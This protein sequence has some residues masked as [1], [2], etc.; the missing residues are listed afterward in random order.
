[1][2]HR[3]SFLTGLAALVAAPAIVRAESLMKVKAEP[4]VGIIEYWDGR[5]IRTAIPIQDWRY[6]SRAVNIDV[7]I[8]EMP[9]TD[10]LA[11]MCRFGAGMER[12]TWPK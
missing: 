3:R 9:D 1:M 6:L 5:I 2:I 11:D 12:V 7:T 8:S 4:L 10:A